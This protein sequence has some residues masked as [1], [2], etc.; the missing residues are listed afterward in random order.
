[1][2]QP[3]NNLG[4]LQ[5]KVL[6]DS[7]AL[8]SQSQKGIAQENSSIESLEKKEEVSLT[9]SIINAGSNILSHLYSSVKSIYYHIFYWKK[10][11]SD[12]EKKRIEL[13]ND[14][15]RIDDC[16]GELVIKLAEKHEISF[17]TF[18]GEKIDENRFLHQRIWAACFSG[19]TTKYEIGAKAIK[20][21]KNGTDTDEG[22]KLIPHLKAYFEKEIRINEIMSEGKKD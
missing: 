16:S 13:I 17:Y 20:E 19:D 4:G 3:V 10:P 5:E 12:L 18:Y 9:Q 14:M 6:M 21:M 8:S 15:Q 22:K 7:Q 2:T 11:K 1:M